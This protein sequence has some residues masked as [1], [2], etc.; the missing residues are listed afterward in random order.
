MGAAQ[1]ITE[2]PFT[3]AEVPLE[4]QNLAWRCLWTFGQEKGLEMRL[5]RIVAYNTAKELAI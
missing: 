3:A 5:K 2:T 1:R 4:R